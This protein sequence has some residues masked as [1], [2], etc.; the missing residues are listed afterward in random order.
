MYLYIYGSIHSFRLTQHT[1]SFTR[2]NV[3]DAYTEST[4]TLDMLYSSIYNISIDTY[5][6]SA[7]NVAI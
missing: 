7:C 1:D 2:P 5:L 3:F 4:C 6:L